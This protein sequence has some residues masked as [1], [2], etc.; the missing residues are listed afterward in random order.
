MSTVDIPSEAQATDEVEAVFAEIRRAFG[1]PFV[2][3]LF[4]VMA[5]NPAY[6]K[7]SWERVKV[8]M[9]PGLLD[10]KTKE[11]IA[12][13][14]SAV[15]GCDY[16]VLAHTAALKSMGVGDGEL[17]ELMAVVDLFSGF[18]KLLE[19]LQVPPDIGA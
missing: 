5:H 18:N 1:M 11:M 12:V 3:N 15:N 17:V 19:G 13:A 8:V 9:G 4:K 10:R 7:A 16:C 2:P 14:V 6:L